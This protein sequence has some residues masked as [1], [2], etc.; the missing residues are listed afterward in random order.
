MLFGV[1]L[2]VPHPLRQRLEVAGGCAVADSK[3]KC[4]AALSLS[5]HTSIGELLAAES[6]TEPI[7]S[8]CLENHQRQGGREEKE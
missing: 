4:T 6:G 7:E 1:S 2:L 3:V 5:F 8:Q